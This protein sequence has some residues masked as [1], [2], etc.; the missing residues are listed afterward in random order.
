[1]THRWVVRFPDQRELAFDADTV[2]GCSGG[3]VLRVADSDGDSILLIRGN[4]SLAVRSDT[5]V[6]I[7]PAPAPEPPPSERP[8]TKPFA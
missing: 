2:E 8:Y 6:T 1:M 5:A 3:G 4:W 7:T